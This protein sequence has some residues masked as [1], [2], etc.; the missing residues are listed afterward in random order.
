QGRTDEA[1]DELEELHEATALW[2]APAWVGLLD[3]VAA[4]DQLLATGQAERA[5]RRLESV[6]GL[7]TEPQPN[8][9]WRCAYAQPLLDVGRPDEARAL[10][11]RV[12]AE[13]GDRPL[14]IQALLVDSLAAERLGLAE[15]S[16]RSLTRA[17]RLSRRERIVRPFL[18]LSSQVR[19]LLEALLETG[20]GYEGYVSELLARLPYADQG[21]DAEN[22]VV[23]EALTA[24]EV[25]VLQAMRGSATNDH[26]AGQMYI[27][28]NTLRSHIKQINRKLG[29]TSR[30]ESVARARR[31]GLI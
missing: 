26:I 2:D 29:T 11:D 28:L 27:S 25:E 8:R 10:V 5:L 9:V 16:L 31:L 7:A 24:R 30:R 6:A 13:S 19:P 3:A 23:V 18:L 12:I 14:E 20:T 4:A 21:E 15:E 1:E 22:P 17:V